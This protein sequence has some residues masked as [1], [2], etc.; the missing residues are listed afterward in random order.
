MTTV[1][2]EV[3][4]RSGEYLTGI[5]VMINSNHPVDHPY[6]AIFAR[7]VKWLAVNMHHFI[8]WAPSGTKH[9]VDRVYRRYGPENGVC[10]CSYS[11]EKGP[12]NGFLHTHMHVTCRLRHDGFVL[13]DLDLLREWIRSRQDIP[14]M[15]RISV[16]RTKDHNRLERYIQKDLPI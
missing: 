1:A 10:E 3:S 7:M 8:I 9:G 14:F 15:P 5:F 16:R 4:S 2:R 6:S 13:L 12:S 11:F